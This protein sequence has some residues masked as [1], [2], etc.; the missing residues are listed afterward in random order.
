MK[1]W[2]DFSRKSNNRRLRII[3]RL[4]S[5]VLRLRT[6]RR[7]AP[8]APTWD[9]SLDVS[10]LRLC[11]P[12][13]F[14]RTIR[15][16]SDHDRFSRDAVVEPI[17]NEL[18][19]NPIDR[20]SRTYLLRYWRGH[21]MLNRNRTAYRGFCLAIGPTMALRRWPFVDSTGLDNCDLTIWWTAAFFVSFLS[22]SVSS[23]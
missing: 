8:C 4:C 6:R 23:I 3:I 18:L 15:S 19:A 20:F 17:F 2:M 12:P 16:I 10:S 13:I 7:D 21:E 5:A 1:S 14:W 22:D 11:R 9:I